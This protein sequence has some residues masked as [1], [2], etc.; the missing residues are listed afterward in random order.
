MTMCDGMWNLCPLLK[1][2]DLA[3]GCPVGVDS[4]QELRLT[5]EETSGLFADL[6]RLVTHLPFVL[7]KTEKVKI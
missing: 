7:L 2:E 1:G 5:E 6:V 3:E 4:G